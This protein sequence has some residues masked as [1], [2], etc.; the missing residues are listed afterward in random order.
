MKTFYYFLG[1]AP[2]IW[3]LLS[4]MELHKVHAFCMEY[5]LMN[6][7]KEK[8]VMSSTQHTFTLFMSMYVVWGIAG[9]FS[10]QWFLFLLLLL[11]SLIPKKV[12]FIRLLDACISF[13]L[14]L[15]IILNRFHFHIDTWAWFK[16]WI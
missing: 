4:I 13:A 16:D 8:Y 9:L 7:R 2:I 6:K 10:S 5:K 1:I 3:E 11:I 15:F 12:I 14:L